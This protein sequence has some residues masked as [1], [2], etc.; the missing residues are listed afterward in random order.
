MQTRIPIR[1]PIS[2]VK[3]GD[4]AEESQTDQSV[5]KEDDHVDSGKKEITNPLV[6]LATDKHS[7]STWTGR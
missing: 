4:S 3:G 2:G 6:R 5:D 1:S 7:R